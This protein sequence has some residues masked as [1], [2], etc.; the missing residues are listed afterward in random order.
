MT[1]TLDFTNALS[2]ITIASMEDL[3]YEVDYSFAD[4]F[5]QIELSLSCLRT[6]RKRNLKEV[7]V[8]S[9]SKENTRVMNN[10]LHPMD[11]GTHATSTKQQIR[12][13]QRR[14]KLSDKGYANAIKH[15]RDVLVQETS[16]FLK[17]PSNRTI[18]ILY[19]EENELYSVPVQP[20]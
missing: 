11:K 2:R 5:G 16:H 6:C 20:T 15:G 3:G 7:L 12:H 10:L 9:S 14:R 4:T 19:M 18:Y 1:P 13:R 17:Q 8:N